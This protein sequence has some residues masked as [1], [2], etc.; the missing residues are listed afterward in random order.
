MLIIVKN[1]NCYSVTHAIDYT[2]KYICIT[3]YEILKCR[4]VY[5]FLLQSDVFHQTRFFNAT[6]NV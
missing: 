2:S 4:C 3:V 1:L 5:S 6:S